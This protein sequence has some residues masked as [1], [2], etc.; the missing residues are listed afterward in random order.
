MKKTL[1]QKIKEAYTQVLNACDNV[2][3]SD[4]D[5]ID[6]N[7][8]SDMDNIKASFENYVLLIKEEKRRNKKKII[9]LKQS[10]SFWKRISF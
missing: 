10:V 3:S 8:S 4:E 6:Y 1:N 9:A 7:L 2:N 5:D